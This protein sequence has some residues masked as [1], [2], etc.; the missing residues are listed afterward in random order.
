ME[1]ADP[2]ILK[3]ADMNSYTCSNILPPK[4]YSV[5]DFKSNDILPMDPDTSTTALL[6]Q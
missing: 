5:A 2:V 1:R 6:F 4:L 3:G